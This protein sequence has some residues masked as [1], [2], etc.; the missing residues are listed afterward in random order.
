MKMKKDNDITSSELLKK[1]V[2]SNL[3]ANKLETMLVSLKK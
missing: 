3:K 2:E 1:I